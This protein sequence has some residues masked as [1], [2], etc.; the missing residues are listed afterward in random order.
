MRAASVQADV[1]EGPALEHALLDQRLHDL[2]H[3]ERVT[4]GLREDQ[5]VHGSERVVLAEQCHH[6]RLRVLRAER[7]QAQPRRTP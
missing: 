1:G 2:F 6:Q 5:L 4:L 3:E 7:L